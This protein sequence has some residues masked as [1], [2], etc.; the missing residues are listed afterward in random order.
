MHWGL[1]DGYPIQGSSEHCPKFDL[2][3]EPNAGSTQDCD[4]KAAFALRIQLLRGLK[5]VFI[6]FFMV[7]PGVLGR[8][9]NDR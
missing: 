2:S 3:K 6:S 8:K 4:K 9:K 1:M 5:P 7:M